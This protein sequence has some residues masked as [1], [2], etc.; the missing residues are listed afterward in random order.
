MKEEIIETKDQAGKLLTNHDKKKTTKRRWL[1]KI[2]VTVIVLVVLAAIGVMILLG[3]SLSAVRDYRE[4]TSEQL[5]TLV[6][7]DKVTEPAKLQEVW[8]G[9]TLSGDYKKT[10][11][12]QSEY[13]KLFTEVKNNALLLKTHNEVVDL[14]NKMAG[15][16]EPLDASVLAAAKRYLSAM[17]VGF[18]DQ[19]ERI[20]KLT[21]L[22]EKIR[23]SAN[24][25]EIN[26]EVSQV[27][28]ENE[29][30]VSELREK[31]NVKI[32]EFR[33]KLGD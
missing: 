32:S 7:G 13:Q 23:G 30:W 22:I 18:S 28:N 29:K 1:K 8:L 2:V 10:N 14:Y 16:S 26:G 24:F 20:Q 9:D 21:A 6:T 33:D 17:E 4:K 3:M 15:S 11:E 5:Q 31:T 12:L 25:E 19:T 27:V